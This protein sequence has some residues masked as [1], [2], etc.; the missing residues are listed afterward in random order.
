MHGSSVCLSN[1]VVVQQDVA[2]ATA[3]LDRAIDSVLTVGSPIEY[4]LNLHSAGQG[5][6]DG[7]AKHLLR[8]SDA[9]ERK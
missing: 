3:E 8:L 7:A 6:P 2:N 5:L 4:I 9:K 1:C